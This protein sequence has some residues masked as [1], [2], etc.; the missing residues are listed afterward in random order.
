MDQ[1]KIPLQF[2]RGLLHIPVKEPTQEELQ[3]LP[4]SEINA[5]SP[6]DP[7]DLDD[8]VDPSAK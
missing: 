6:W 1:Q 2:K 8:E 4:V 5:D 7:K 3:L